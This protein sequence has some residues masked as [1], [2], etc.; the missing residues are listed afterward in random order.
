MWEI[1]G[2]FNRLVVKALF[3]FAS[4]TRG[5]FYYRSSEHSCY[6]G[7]KGRLLGLVK[8]EA[9][10]DESLVAF[11]DSCGSAFRLGPLYLSLDTEVGSDTPFF[12]SRIDLV[13]WNY[14]LRVERWDDAKVDIDLIWLGD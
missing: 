11:V 8:Y 13:V 2:R 10:Y 9:S 7:A 5:K 3:R 6:T 4:L 1:L 14:L 12:G